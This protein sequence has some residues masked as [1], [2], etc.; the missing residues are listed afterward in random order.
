MD[1]EMHRG[2]SVR[3]QDHEGRLH[4]FLFTSCVVTCVSYVLAWGTAAYADG[5]RIPYQGAAAAGQG[6]AFA[7]QADDPSAIYYNPAGMTQLRG[8]QVYAGI[9]LIGGNISFTSPTNVTAH[10]DL[11]GTIVFPPPSNMYITANMADFGPAFMK[12]LSLGLGLN[13]PFGLGTRYPN[14]GPFASAVT[15]SSFPVLDIKPTIA[16]KVSDYIS[17]GL[18]ADIYTFAHFNHD[19]QFELKS[20]QPPGISTEL[21]GSD[22]AAG[23]NASLLVTP[24]RNADGDPLMNLGVVYRSRTTLHLSGQLVVNGISTDATTTVVLPPVLTGAIAVWPIRDRAH[25][26]KV[27]FDMDFVQWNVFRNLDVHFSN[28]TSQQIPENWKT[29]YTAMVGSQYKWLQLEAL[30]A[31]EV[32]VRAGYDRQL[33]PVPAAFFTPGIPDSDKNV[34]TVGAG[35]LCKEGG[36]FM[37]LLQCGDS[38]ARLLKTKAIGLDLAYQAELFEPRTI[39]GNVNPTVNGTY[40]TTI[41]VGSVNVRLMF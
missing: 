1:L 28:G 26:W 24:L 5:F 6:F 11:G 31:W 39:S 33:T 37:G 23:F 22:T 9:D 14:N 30:P 10:G 40:H 12:N 13:T 38:G 29:T 3:T 8:L 19:G 2:L 21:N 27:E 41:H 18:G 35:F 17:V 4:F 36:Y 20:T 7:A 32:A 34:I 16:Y 15:R 25:E